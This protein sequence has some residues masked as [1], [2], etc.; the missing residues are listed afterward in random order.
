MDITASPGSATVDD[1]FDHP[2]S[3]DSLGPQA[4]QMLQF[5][6]GRIIGQDR[7]LQ[8][9]TRRFAIHHAGLG[10]GRRPIAVLLF[11]GPTGVGKTMTA[12]EVARYVIGDELLPPLLR[13]Q[14]A[15]F[16]EHHEVAKL[17]GSP[18]GYVRSNEPGLLS[19]LKIDEADFWRR[20]RPHLEKEYKGA[21]T[22]QKMAEL[23][24]Q[25]Y[26][27]FGPFTSVILFDEIEKA[28]RALH[29]LLLHIVD[30]GELGMND[31]TVT[32][33]NN[34]VIIL[35]SNVGGSQQQDIIDGKGRPVG[36]QSAQQAIGT[37]QLIYEETIKMIEKFFPPE[38]IGR[39]KRGIVVF[40][41]L[42]RDACA[43]IL[44]NMLQS[45]QQRALQRN[46]RS[47][48]VVLHFSPEFR[49]ALL[50]RGDV[51]KYGARPLRDLVEKEVTLRLANA[52]TSGELRECDEI[53]FSVNS[54]SEIVLLRKRRCP[55][56]RCR[57]AI[58][59]LDER[60]T[61]IV[62]I[63]KVNGDGEDE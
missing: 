32:R 31:G 27:R 45:V 58:P 50:T 57:A 61:A 49:E 13:I 34:S 18:P 15:S 29:N 55:V 2:I 53:L 44:D 48:P 16:R 11:T 8:Y 5:L 22:K 1:Q 20:V 4:E 10:D 19:Q 39:M 52:I 62:P 59:L 26:Q 6:R 40:R 17:I 56:V 43:K 47:I 21:P 54:S 60:G 14:C 35:T 33:F 25:L 46:E 38:F 7:A 63:V 41:T 12:E 28:D 36:F 9:V 42:D 51:R 23:M 37:D 3:T 30:D 24:P